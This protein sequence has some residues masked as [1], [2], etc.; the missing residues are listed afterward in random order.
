MVSS[1]IM[2]LTYGRDFDRK[3]TTADA[4]SILNRA[5]LPGA[6]P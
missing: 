6:S 2:R 3:R 4:K 1:S 5:F